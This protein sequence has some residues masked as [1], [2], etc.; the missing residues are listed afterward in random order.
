MSY[1]WRLN[2]DKAL[3]AAGE[4]LAWNESGAGPDGETGKIA[5]NPSRWGDVVIAR[6]DTPTSYHLSVVVDDALQGITHVVRGRDLFHATSV[7]RLLQKLLGL[8]EPHYHHHDLVLGDDGLKLSKS[9]MDTALA[10]LREQGFT[11][12]D[13]RAKLKL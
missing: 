1:A 6:K 3:A 10:S 11:P 7:H 4:P 9:R 8:P 12:D 2:M 5:A 13:I